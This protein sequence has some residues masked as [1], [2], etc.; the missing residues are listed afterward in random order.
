MTSRDPEEGPNAV[1]SRYASSHLLVPVV[2]CANPHTRYLSFTLPVAGVGRLPPAG[3]VYFLSAHRKGEGAGVCRM[4]PP[5][6]RED[7]VPP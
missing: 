7:P 3:L 5:E 6:G 1:A 4:G 2:T